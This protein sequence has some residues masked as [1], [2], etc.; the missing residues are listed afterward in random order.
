MFYPEVIEFM[1]DHSN[2][3]S[4]SYFILDF[5]EVLSKK[6]NLCTE[7]CKPLIFQTSNILPK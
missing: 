3:H 5:I 2:Q 7:S 6:I 4:L 1:I